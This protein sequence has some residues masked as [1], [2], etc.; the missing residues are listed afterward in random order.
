VNKNSPHL[1]LTAEE[2]RD[3]W[4]TGK[5]YKPAGYLL[6][7]L[8]AMRQDGWS[9]RFNVKEFCLLWGLTERSFF[10][11]KAELIQLDLISEKIHGE[12]ELTVLKKADKTGGS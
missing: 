4:K 2:V 3:R 10:R 11:A 1:R 12:I 7:L 8:R 9:L 5:V 6:D